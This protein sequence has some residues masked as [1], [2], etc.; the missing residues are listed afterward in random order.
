M[1]L[2]NLHGGLYFLEMKLSPAGVNAV[3]EG[4]IS[5]RR[6]YSAPPL[7]RSIMRKQLRMQTQERKRFIGGQV[8][9]TGVA[10]QKRKSHLLELELEMVVGLSNVDGGNKIW[11]FWTS[12]VPS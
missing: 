9:C 12:G 4:F 6:R 8:M 1:A 7:S 11:N 3:K 5:E 2:I 10:G